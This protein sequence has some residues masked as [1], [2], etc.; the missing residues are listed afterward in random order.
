[1]ALLNAFLSVF[2]TVTMLLGVIVLVDSALK[3]LSV[4][5]ED[6]ELAALDFFWSPGRAGM[7]QE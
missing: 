7:R 1:M 3:F 2:L 6:D 5:E 4:D